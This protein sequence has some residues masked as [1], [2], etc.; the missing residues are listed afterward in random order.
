[1]E[2]FET[3]GI[4]KIAHMLGISKEAIRK[5]ESRNLLINVRDED[6]GYRKYDT[7]DMAG[8]LQVRQ[9]RGMGLSLDSIERL[10]NRGS[11]PDLAEE[12]ARKKEEAEKAVLKYQ[13]L[14][15]ML[16]QQEEKLRELIEN[17]GRDF[18][19]EYRPPL[20]VIDI[21]T[22]RTLREENEVEAICREWLQKVP[23]AFQAGRFDEEQKDW[24][25]LLAIEEQYAGWIGRER[26]GGVVRYVPSKLCACVPVELAY[27]VNITKKDMQPW[28]D[29]IR[30]AGYTP[31]G[32][33]MS[34]EILIA[35]RDGKYSYFC[36]I[37]IQIE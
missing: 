12:V 8:L 29:R 36:K 14:F 28:M 18:W 3:Y 19:I 31:A 32:D 9:L 5:Y 11:L 17:Q 23:F 30:E 24:I 16:K 25:H 21:G 37:W 20:Y 35:K 33:P 13:K 22:T 7:W 6:N 34:K 4:T 10:V 26:L 15:L 1:M 27:R 2:P